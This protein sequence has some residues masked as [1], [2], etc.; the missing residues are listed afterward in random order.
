ML[1]LILPTLVIGVVL[2]SFIRPKWAVY[3]I[4]PVLFSYPHAWWFYK[5]LLPMNIGVDDLLI[6]LVF[7]G[8][9]VNRH[10]VRRFPVRRSWGLWIGVS[11]LILIA[12]ANLSSW[13]SAG[14]VDQIAFLKRMM[15]V[16]I[17]FALF[18]ATLA[19]VDDDKDV[20]RMLTAFLLASAAGAGIIIAQY[21]NPNLAEIFNSPEWLETRI[22]EIGGRTGGAF[23]SPNIAANVLCVAALASIALI[24]VW[25]NPLMRMAIWSIIVMFGL[26][27][28][29]TQ[30]RSGLVAFMLALL[31]FAFFG[32][33]RAYAWPLIFGMIVV[34]FLMPDIRAGIAERFVSAFRSGVAMESN[35]AARL[36]LYGEYLGTMHLRD[37]IIGRS[38]SDA[39]RV[40]GTHPHSSYLALI[41][42]YGIPGVIWAV[43]FF[44]TAMSRWRRTV[45]LNHPTLSP[46]ASAIG[47]GMVGWWICALAIDP[48]NAQYGRYVFLL[49]IAILDRSY[50]LS[51]AKAQASVASPQQRPY[52]ASPIRP[53]VPAMR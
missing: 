26:A 49:M 15:K 21:F 47:W 23:I 1:T 38:V 19:T 10:L 4:W 18:Y 7:V 24:G 33:S 25:R 32:R 37:W 9:V 35:V 8:V 31:G 36:G 51:F 2:L 46:I 3:L 16:G 27:L 43:A 34:A 50:V 22:F 14:A 39:V 29:M 28:L 42:L 30:S 53:A 40:V 52:G 45:Q 48:I 12:L 44:T 11:L 41:S 13:A 20:V 5:Q 17:F 6:L